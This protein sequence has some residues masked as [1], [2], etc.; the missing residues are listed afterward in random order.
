MEEKVNVDLAVAYRFLHPMHTVL[1]TSVGKEGKPN[2]ITLAWVMPTSN[3][4]PLVAISVSPKRYSE[5]LIRE[6]GEFI[7]N[8]P[9]AKLLSQTIACGSI[10]G[11]D[12]DKFKETSLTA[13]QAK[14]SEYQ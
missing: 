6:S 14:K 13:V 8:I 3:D 5:K 1:V 12:Y 4:P 9:T 7:I 2:I 10:S 11:R